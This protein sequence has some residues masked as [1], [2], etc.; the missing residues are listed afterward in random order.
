MQARL[1]GVHFYLEARAGPAEFVLDHDK[2]IALF[3]DLAGCPAS[4]LLQRGGRPYL[5]EHFLFG[6]PNWGSR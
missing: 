4:I 5:R 6:Q 1:L 3:T 2:K